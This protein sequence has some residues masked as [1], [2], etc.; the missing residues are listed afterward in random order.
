VIRLATCS[1]VLIGLCLGAARS[2]DKS[3]PKQGEPLTKDGLIGSKWKGEYNGGTVEVTFRST[4]DR[5]FLSVLLVINTG[6]SETIGNVPWDLDA[7]KNEIKFG[8]A[9]AKPAKDG[10]LL[11]NGNVMLGLTTFTFKEVRIERA[12][13]AKEPKK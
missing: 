3:D 10:S 11:L 7:K 4:K 8:D 12:T 9:T 6:S 5:Q 2:Q 1:L 13:A